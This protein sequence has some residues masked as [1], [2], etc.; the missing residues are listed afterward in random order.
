MFVP[1]IPIV[2][3]VVGGLLGGAVLGLVVT[4]GRFILTPLTG[5]STGLLIASIAASVVGLLW[6]QARRW[7]PERTCQVSD[8]LI[9]KSTR[10]A[11]FRWGLVLGAGVCTYLVTP[12]IYAMLGVAMAQ[13]GFLS[14]G[15][16]CTSYGLARTLAI[17]AFVVLR[18]TQRRWRTTEPGEGLERALRVPL[19][20]LSIAAVWGLTR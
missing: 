12:A 4:A 19:A 13:R 1:W 6:P 5:A 15:L 8:A 2:C 10:W 3:L 16:I 17:A 20:A 18:R 11:G 7:L 14:S 9:G